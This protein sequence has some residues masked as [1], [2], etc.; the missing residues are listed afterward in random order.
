VCH[1]DSSGRPRN[2]ISIALSVGKL[3]ALQEKVYDQLA[4]CKPFKRDGRTG[5]EKMKTD[6]YI[7]T[8]I[9]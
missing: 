1:K 6:F 3:L 9:S 5:W 2:T 8:E 4:I 7:T